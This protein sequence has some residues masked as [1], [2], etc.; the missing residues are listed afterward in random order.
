VLGL[1]V[2]GTLLNL[3]GQRERSREIY[4]LNRR[5]GPVDFTRDT[6]FLYGTFYRLTVSGTF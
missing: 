1:K 3:I 6:E 5:N 2:R 4:Y